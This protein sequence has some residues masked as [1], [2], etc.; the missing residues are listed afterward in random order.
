MKQLHRLEDAA[1][2]VMYFFNVT[3]TFLPFS[4]IAF[5][6]ALQAGAFSPWGVWPLEAPLWQV[7]LS[8]IAYYACCRLADLHLFYLAVL[9]AAAGIA[10]AGQAIP[11]AAAAAAVFFFFALTSLIQIVFMGLPM[12]MASRSPDVA[13]RMY[14]NS[15]A[16]LAPTTISLPVTLGYQFL[17][18]TAVMTTAPQP[19]SKPAAATAAVMV[20]G[21]LATRRLKKRAFL[22]PTH[23]PAPNPPGGRRAVVLNL[24]GVSHHGF[25]RADAP[26]LHSL[27]KNFAAAPGGAHTVYKA[28]TNPA[29]ASILSGAEPAVHRVVNNNFGQPIRAEALP[30]LLK[31]R[32]YG[33]MHVKHFS[34]KAW[35][36]N[37][38]S[39]VELA[40]DR[41]DAALME[42]L[43]EDLLRHP[44]TRLWV[45]DLSLADYC[46]H[47][48]GSY[49]HQYRDAIAAPGPTHQRFLLLVP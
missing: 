23:H 32:L 19:L 44:D 13:L 9:P 47:A 15:F 11:L 39:L 27:E 7:A 37:L 24:D 35:K 1:V 18:T 48:W 5:V 46:G 8:L 30:D 36:V 25:S 41:A 31:T 16:I 20:A 38:V 2:R 6:A 3:D 4:V 29:F 17:L 10:I 43:K 21:A 40:Y 12:A 42:T 34:K 49:S 33:S 28:F 22:P 14:I 26:F 45:V